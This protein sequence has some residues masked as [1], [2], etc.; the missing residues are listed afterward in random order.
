V[1]K[2]D[3]QAPAASDEEL[4]R[5]ALQGSQRAL[6][7]LVGRHH[8]VVYRIVFGILGDG[9]AASDAA[10][11]T[12]LKAFRALDRF[13]GEARFRTWLLT[14]AS[15]VARGMLRQKER[16]RERPLDDAPDVPDQRSDTSGEVSRSE[17]A[18]RVAELL[19][20]LPEK[21][22]LA[23]QLRTQEGLGFREVGEIIGSTE[24]AARVNYH[25][26]IRRLREMLK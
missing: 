24:G 23:V 11:D 13:R 3:D 21:Q 6:D 12:F 14:I 25:H 20:K 17:E 9:D 8:T 18:E 7:E 1:A 2:S 4:V 26:G 15:N 10:Q 5:Q 19:S 16:R 22:R